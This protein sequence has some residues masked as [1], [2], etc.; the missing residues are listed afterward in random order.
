MATRFVRLRG[1]Q[2]RRLELSPLLRRR[3]SRLSC[4]S[5]F[6]IRYIFRLAKLAVRDRSRL[7]RSFGYDSDAKENVL[8]TIYSRSDRSPLGESMI[9]THRSQV[10]SIL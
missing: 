6:N 7:K 5:F 10:R 4:L 2:E 1:P 8:Y 9:F 3:G